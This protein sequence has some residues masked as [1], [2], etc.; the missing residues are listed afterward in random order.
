MS[1]RKKEK[2]NA[3]EASSGGQ[4]ADSISY[5]PPPTGR[6][7][8]R[9]PVAAASASQPG[10]DT[11][12]PTK[13]KPSAF[14]QQT[15]DMLAKSAAFSASLI[16]VPEDIHHNFE[17]TPFNEIAELS[18]QLRQ[19]TGDPDPSGLIRAR[20]LYDVAE[21]ALTPTVFTHQEPQSTIFSALRITLTEEATI[22]IIELQQGSVEMD[23]HPMDN[24]EI[25]ELII[26][27]QAAAGLRF[28]AHLRYI[29]ASNALEVSRYSITEALTCL[30]IQRPKTQLP[31]PDRDSAIPADILSTVSQ[32]KGSLHEQLARQH[33]EQQST[34]IAL[35]NPTD[36]LSQRSGDARSTSILISS[37]SSS[38]DLDPEEEDQED[39]QEDKHLA[40]YSAVAAKV[41]AERQAL[42]E[43][44]NRLQQEKTIFNQDV[45]HWQEQQKTAESFFAPAIR[46]ENC[47]AGSYRSQATESLYNRAIAA[48]GC[49]TLHE[50]AEAI[51]FVR[52]KVTGA[53]NLDTAFA[54]LTPNIARSKGEGRIQLSQTDKDIRVLLTRRGTTFGRRDLCKRCGSTHEYV[55]SLCTSLRHVDG[56]LCTALPR[57]EEEHRIMIKITHN[58]APTPLQSPREHAS[59]ALGAAQGTTSASV[60]ASAVA[61]AS[62]QALSSSALA[63]DHPASSAHLDKPFDMPAYM[64]SVKGNT[65]P[66]FQQ[67][68]TKQSLPTS[69][70]MEL[71]IIAQAQARISL[72]S[73][74]K[75]PKDPF[76]Y[77]AAVRG[78]ERLMAPAKAAAKAAAA[79]AAVEQTASAVE[80]VATAKLGRTREL[81]IAAA[82]GSSE[83]LRDSVR[84]KQEARSSDDEQEVLRELKPSIACHN[85]F[86]P[87]RKLSTRTKHG[88][89]KNDFIASS[90]EDDEEDECEEEEDQSDPDYSPS[91]STTPSVNKSLKGTRRLTKSDAEELDAFRR[92]QST[93]TAS[94]IAN[95]LQTS[96]ASQSPATSTTIVKSQQLDAHGR[97]SREHLPQY[98]HKTKPPTHGD[99]DNIDYFMKEY[100]PLYDKYRATCGTNYFDTIFEGYTP[101]QKIRISRFL[102]REINGEVIERS[103]EYLSGI[104]NDEFVALM[105]STRGYGTTSLTEIALRKIQFKGPLTDR[106]AWVNLET[107]WEECLQQTSKNG[108]IDKKRLIIIYKEC[109]P[110]SFFQTNLAQQR[111]DN[112]S[113]A[114]RHALAQITNPC[115]LVPWMEDLLKRKTSGDPKQKQAGGGPTIP[116]TPAV[117]P[118]PAG[119]FDPLTFKDRHGSLNINPNMKQNLNL[120][121]TN[122]VCE[123][124][125][126]THKWLTEMCSDNSSADGKKIEPPQTFAENV[127]RGILRW[128]AGFFFRS[129]PKSW[130]ETTERFTKTPKSP[131]VGGTA[132]DAATSARTLKNP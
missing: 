23:D 122:I 53:V 66:L 111:F 33:E 78:V 132:H 80:R 15:Q 58:F 55:D 127:R 91:S 48:G 40:A 76:S 130:K 54:I 28:G 99:W 46:M 49:I 5:S 128:I 125:G 8:T 43:D 94:L 106:S 22:K 44:A 102:T 57:E 123:R 1:G 105:C 85:M 41:E 114:H 131:S 59:S 29:V 108:I 37:S 88:H 109:I 27:L 39:E 77:Q 35:P 72:L 120:N 89:V 104:P 67:K 31:L 19:Q 124:C 118:G 70:Q 4:S 107:D 3:K 100:M 96:Q 79:S 117:K 82:T 69:L 32:R 87:L 45:I 68:Q 113:Q 26:K 6:T 60:R 112:W 2:K 13:R 34:N 98:D 64:E 20:Q 30:Q 119:A 73:K 11:P 121:P 116:T 17:A 103:V 71:D 42:I 115:F 38:E 10:S 90:D 101:T 92:N 9:T 52:N 65:E 126:R 86:E 61:K 110:D 18:Q 25:T 56:H 81:Q 50:A 74:Q 63:P 12:N 84:I 83:E 97:P 24:L 62:A 21:T 95:M 16:D 129:D 7:L 51:A 47:T 14:H 75:P 36:K 93:L